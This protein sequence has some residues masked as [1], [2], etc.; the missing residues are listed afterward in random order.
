MALNIAIQIVG[1]LAFT[2]GAAISITKGAVQFKS[3]YQLQRARDP[4][5][6]WA[7]V[8][9]LGGTGL[10]FFISPATRLY[11]YFFESL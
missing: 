3:G 4:L 9:I 1:G 11:Q 8:I 2:A 6:F 5:G 10:F 7:A